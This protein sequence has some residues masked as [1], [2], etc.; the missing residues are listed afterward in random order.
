MKGAD[1]VPSSEW[2]ECTERQRAAEVHEG[3]SLRNPLARLRQAI[4]SRDQRVVGD[5]QKND[6]VGRRDEA[7]D[8]SRDAGSGGPQLGAMTRSF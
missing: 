7:P 1:R 4:G 6:R 2:L 3:D 5:G 8:Q